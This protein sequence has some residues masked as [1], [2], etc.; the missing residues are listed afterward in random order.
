MKN[1]SF[2]FKF[3]IYN[4]VKYVEERKLLF[5]II[6]F[7]PNI[8]FLKYVVSKKISS[9]MYKLVMVSQVYC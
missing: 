4:Y 8:Y 5:I 6:L 1:S 2:R 3:W 7:E 9:L